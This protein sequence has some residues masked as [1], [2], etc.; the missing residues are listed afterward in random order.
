MVTGRAD[1]HDGTAYVPAPVDE[2]PRDVQRRRT[3]GRDGSRHPA[4]PT[5]TAFEEALLFALNHAGVADRP[6]VLA[7]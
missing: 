3:S 7:A 2:R 1:K 5:L 4:S 6:E